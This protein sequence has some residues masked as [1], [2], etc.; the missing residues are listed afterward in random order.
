MTCFHYGNPGHWKRNC[1]VYFV[2]MKAGTSDVP[3]GMYKI[4]TAFSLSSSA[5]NAWVLDTACGSPICKSLQG[6]QRIRR[7]KKDEF[8]LFGASGETISAEA[9]GTYLLELSKGRTLEL[10]FCYYMPNVIRNIISVPVLLSYGYEIKFMGQGCSIF[11]SNEFIGNRFFDNGLLVLSLN[12]NMF[13]IDKNMKRKKEDINISYLLHCCLGHINETR[14]SKLFKE[15]YFEPYD[16]MSYETCESCLMEKMTKSPFPGHG[17]RAKELLALVHSDVCGPMST[18]ARGGYS[19]FITFTD[20]LSRFGFVYLMKH[21][22][23]AFDK[24]KEY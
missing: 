3:K 2:S 1:K 10:K 16:F 4:H 17:E 21:K 12:E 5:N 19:Y 24:F 13:H 14:I 22:S 8:K 18:Q 9:M 11:Y 7:L 20:D 15:K 23:E 6:L